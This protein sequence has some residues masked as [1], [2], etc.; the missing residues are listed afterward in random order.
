MSEYEAERSAKPPEPALELARDELP[1]REVL[2]PGPTA[3]PRM[4][5]T[6]PRRGCMCR[7]RAD[8][9]LDDD[10]GALA[11]MLGGGAGIGT[12]F[13]VRSIRMRCEG[14]RRTVTDLDDDERAR[15]RKGRAKVTLV[16]LALMAAAAICALTWWHAVRA[17]AHNPL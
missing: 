1:P 12:F 17:R 6:P 4:D 11:K 5:M 3:S 2:R 9:F 10:F 7:S 8:V 14:C 13:L 15:V 16:T